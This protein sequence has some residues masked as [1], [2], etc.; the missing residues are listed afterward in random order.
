MLSKVKHRQINVCACVC[1]RELAIKGEGVALGTVVRFSV[2]CDTFRAAESAKL[3]SRAESTKALGAYRK[4]T[5][6][7][8]RKPNLAISVCSLLLGSWHN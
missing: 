3:A 7:R 1:P 2:V 5:R 4:M 8:H 6:F